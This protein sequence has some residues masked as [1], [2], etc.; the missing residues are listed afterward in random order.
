MFQRGEQADEQ[1]KRDE[2][3]KRLCLSTA[4]RIDKKADINYRGC[5]TAWKPSEKSSA[6]IYDS[7]SS[8]IITSIEENNRQSIR[9][10]TK[11]ITASNKNKHTPSHT[12]VPR[13]SYQV[14][15]HRKNASSTL[16]EKASS[17]GRATVEHPSPTQP[18]SMRVC[19]ESTDT[20]SVQD[21]NSA[22]SNVSPDKSNRT[23]PSQ[24]A[25]EDKQQR[26]ILLVS[27]ST[28]TLLDK[29]RIIPIRV[30][31]KCRAA[32]IADAFHKIKF[33]GTHPMEKRYFVLGLMT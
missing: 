25:R 6:D 14:N 21:E 28:A 1:H 11:V 19:D 32:T 27:D 29:R 12:D 13:S 2:S 17:Q 26:N 5:T 15:R 8:E 23:S 16:K 18:S 30:I 24:S 33:G 22:S 4:E 10:I 31:S 9:K 3:N 7:I 20:A